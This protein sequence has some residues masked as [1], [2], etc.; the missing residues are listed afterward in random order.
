MSTSILDKFV[1][2]FW[3]R[4]R[5]TTRLQPR[6]YRELL[7]ESNHRQDALE[8]IHREGKICDQLEVELLR[9]YPQFQYAT[10][11][12]VSSYRQF[13]ET[14]ITPDEGYYAFRDLYFKTE[15]ASNNLISKGLSTVFPKPSIPQSISSI[16]GTF[17]KSDVLKIVGD[18]RHD[19][20]AKIDARISPQNT[21]D[22]NESVIGEASRNNGSNILEQTASRTFY[23]ES[24]LLSVP[25]VNRIAADPLIYFVA[26]EY[27]AVEP[28]LIR[29]AVW[30]SRPHDNSYETLSG[31]AQLFHV[32]MSNPKFFQV[33]IYLNDVNEN[34]G[35]HCVV[36]GT[37]RE[38]SKALWR[39]GRVS[40]DEIAAYYPRE[41]WKT[42]LGPT[43]TI[44]IV[45][46]SAF[47]KGCAPLTGERR[48]ASFYYAN[49][50]FGQHLPVTPDTAVFNP[51]NFGKQVE[52]FSP[53]FF[54]RLAL[55]A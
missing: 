48:M 8:R 45:D 44:F 49:T 30:A 15:G 35:P 11:T 25:I 6:T 28:I 27:L 13:A 18:L 32:D 46:T 53:R 14:G 17:T 19:C 43:G 50:L 52:D 39:D 42:E 22:F 55:G 34:N 21:H 20:I 26:S 38:K 2:K 12:L 37:H 7:A 54:S 23:K 51:A 40:D 10:Q 5:N 31:G 33:F 29:P 9:L 41:T 24:A 16:L 3:K 47:H 1:S 4:D 36:P